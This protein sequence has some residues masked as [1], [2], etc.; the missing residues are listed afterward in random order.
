MIEDLQQLLE[1]LE[2][3]ERTRAVVANQHLLREHIIYKPLPDLTPLR[4]IIY[5]LRSV[6][7]EDVFLSAIATKIL[8]D[9]E[10]EILPVEQAVR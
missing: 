3:Y 1:K 9:T 2:H 6:D 4:R 7:L 8:T 5:L 10:D